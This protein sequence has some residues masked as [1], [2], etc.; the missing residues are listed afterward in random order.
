MF[1]LGQENTTSLL[2]LT[3]DRMNLAY[4]VQDRYIYITAERKKEHGAIGYSRYPLFQD[5]E[6]LID[7]RFEDYDLYQ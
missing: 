6:A 2:A 7:Q 3:K 4:S 5:I 1:G